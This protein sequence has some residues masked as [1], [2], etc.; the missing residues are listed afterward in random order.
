MKTCRVEFPGTSKPAVDLEVGV[1][2]SENLTI[3][4][5]PILFGCRIGICGTCAVEVVS[6]DDPLPER[7]FD[8]AQFLEAMAPGQDSV[9]LACQ[10]RIS[11][12][13]K[14]RKTQV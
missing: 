8:E 9:R 4:N 3:H 2:L 10:I 7:T 5:S 12:N 11:T 13:M 6:A 14:L 1:N